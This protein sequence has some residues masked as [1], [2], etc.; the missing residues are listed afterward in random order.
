MDRSRDVLRIATFTPL[1][2]I[3]RAGAAVLGQSSPDHPPAGECGPGGRDALTSEA[4]IGLAP[5]LTDPGP[6]FMRLTQ[7]RDQ[8]S[9][10]SRYGARLDQSLALFVREDPRPEPRHLGKLQDEAERG[11][12]HNHNGTLLRSEFRFQ[13]A[14]HRGHFFRLPH[15]GAVDKGNTEPAGDS[16][17]A[18]NKCAS[19]PE[20]VRNLDAGKAN[21]LGVPLINEVVP[22]R[23]ES[24]NVGLRVLTDPD[25]APG[26]AGRLRQDRRIQ[27]LAGAGHVRG[28]GS[29]PR[30]ELPEVVTQKDPPVK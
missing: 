1:V 21:A 25:V 23:H 13:A 22:Q 24:L 5:P 4:R 17:V 8:G 2:L 18:G 7:D 20:D 10:G 15:H 6:E 9:P 16:D 28:P 27:I 26:L 3:R 19:R 29:V 14:D 12:D 30:P 11:L